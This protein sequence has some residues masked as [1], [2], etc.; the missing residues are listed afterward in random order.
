MFF[1]RIIIKKKH[2][3]TRKLIKNKLKQENPLW[4]PPEKKLNQK[5]KV[6]SQN[7]IKIKNYISSNVMLTFCNAAAK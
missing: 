3:K 7:K 1:N 5:Q 2:P 4:E 6:K